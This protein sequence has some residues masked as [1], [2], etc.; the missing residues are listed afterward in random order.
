[1]KDKFDP[2]EF[3]RNYIKK[4]NLANKDDLKVI[5]KSNKILIDKA[6]EEALKDPEP[7]QSALVTTVTS[8]QNKDIRTPRSFNDI[9]KGFKR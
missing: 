8:E 2:I 5:D 9:L 1:M 4:H 7:S 6:I 3:L